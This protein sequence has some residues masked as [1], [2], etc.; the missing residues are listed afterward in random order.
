MNTKLPATFR[1]LIFLL[2][3]GLQLANPLFARESI[4]IEVVEIDR[5]SGVLL[6]LGAI[7]DKLPH[8]LLGELDP[9]ECE[10]TQEEERHMDAADLIS[11]ALS[12]SEHLYQ[13]RTAPNC[14]QVYPILRKRY[15]AFHCLRIN[16]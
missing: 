14:A 6:E 16:C 12:F 4:S 10:E 7:P 8:S 2:L 1:F 9:A 3:F 11:A 13:L 15:L 5:E